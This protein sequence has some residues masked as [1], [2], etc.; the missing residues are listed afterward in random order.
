MDK[1]TLK[2]ANKLQKKIDQ[3][4]DCLNLFEWEP[5]FS[6][7]KRK[8]RN[9]RLCIDADDEEGGRVF[10][11]IPMDL[12]DEIIQTIKNWIEIESDRVQ[13]EFY[14]LTPTISKDEQN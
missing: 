9:P 3:L 6:N 5:T 13:T 8:S 12:N 10:V 1:E 14:H 4:N 2:K 7:E 11:Q